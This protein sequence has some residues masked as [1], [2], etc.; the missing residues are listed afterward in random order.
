MLI[1]FLATAISCLEMGNIVLQP[2]Q[3]AISRNKDTFIHML[4]HRVSAP[5][6]V[7][8]IT[9]PNLLK[10]WFLW[11]FIPEV[12]SDCRLL[13]QWVSQQ[14]K[15]LKGFHFHLV[16]FSHAA[17]V[18]LESYWNL[19]NGSLF[20]YSD[21]HN[22][23]YEI[24]KFAWREKVFMIQLERCSEFVYYETKADHLIILESSY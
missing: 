17:A 3:F 11:H 7:V 23:K 12:A 9:I 18:L 22:W 14:A 19:W 1:L 21:C 4:F 2:G 5:S 20:Y 10:S 16:A 24:E 15:N 13:Q 6:L 8:F